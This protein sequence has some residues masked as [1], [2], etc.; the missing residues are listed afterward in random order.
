MIGKWQGIGERCFV[1]SH[2]EA[3]VDARDF[4]GALE[5][6]VVTFADPVDFSEDLP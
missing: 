1:R 2:P 5:A 4:D 6:P 3:R